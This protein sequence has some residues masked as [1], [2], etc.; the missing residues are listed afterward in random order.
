MH[1]SAARDRGNG[2]SA[3]AAGAGG[4]GGSPSPKSGRPRRSK[5][6]GKWGWARGTSRGPPKIKI[7]RDDDDLYNGGKW[8]AASARSRSRIDVVFTELWTT[9]WRV[10]WMVTFFWFYLA[11]KG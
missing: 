4:F 7:G 1:P 10:T 3:T 6:Q 11:W 8:K 9:V 2:L 5:E